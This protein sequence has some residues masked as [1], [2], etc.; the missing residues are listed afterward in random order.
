MVALPAKLNDE[1]KLEMLQGVLAYAVD[2]NMRSFWSWFEK[3]EEVWE[4]RKKRTTTA[5]LSGSTIAIN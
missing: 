5:R 2:A 4:E 1:D 3:T